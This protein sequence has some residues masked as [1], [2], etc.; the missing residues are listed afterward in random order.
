MAKGR[1]ASLVRPGPHIRIRLRDEGP[2]SPSD[3]HRSYD[4]AC[5]GTKITRASRKASFHPRY[6]SFLRYIHLFKQLGLIEPVMVGRGRT[7][8]YRE[9]EAMYPYLA[10]RH[11]YQL[12][13]RGLALGNDSEFWSNPWPYARG[14]STEAEAEA[15][16]IAREEAE[17]RLRAIRER[18][19]VVPKKRRKVRKAEEVPPPEEEVVIIEEEPRDYAQIIAGF[20][21]EYYALADAIIL[22]VEAVREDPSR[23]EEL[24]EPLRGIRSLVER[25]Q[26]MMASMRRRDRPP[27]YDLAIKVFTDGIHCLTDA[28]QLYTLRASS[29]VTAIEDAQRRG[30][31]APERSAWESFNA[32]LDDIGKCLERQRV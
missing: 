13:D 31:T 20:L 27:E 15:L 5:A 24:D 7:R 28:I 1:A 29:A 16:D 4:F 25:R 21:Q 10:P 22:L 32:A 23:V 26:A 19:E 8:T 18:E 11:F 9:E 2:L 30:L 17:A 12:T 6:Q 14:I 3:L